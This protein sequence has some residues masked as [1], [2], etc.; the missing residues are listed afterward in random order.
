MPHGYSPLPSMMP[1]V[2]WVG[3][4]PHLAG[5]LCHPPRTRASQP[6]VTITK[7][8]TDPEYG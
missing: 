1:G 8:P 5:L 4:Q 2:G 7:Y 3:P 6:A